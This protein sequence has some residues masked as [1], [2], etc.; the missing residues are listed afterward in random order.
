MLL[1]RSIAFF[2]YD[3]FQRNWYASTM[4]CTEEQNV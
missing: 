3:G 2:L 4:I 1:F